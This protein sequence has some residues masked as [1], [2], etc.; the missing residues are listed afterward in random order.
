MVFPFFL[1]VFQFIQCF[2]GKKLRKPRRSSPKR[3]FF[4]VAQFLIS[5]DDSHG[6][7]LGNRGQVL[8]SY[9]RFGFICP[10]TGFLCRTTGAA[11]PI[12]RETSDEKRCDYVRLKTCALQPRTMVVCVAITFLFEIKLS[13]V[14]ICVFF[15]CRVW[16]A[17]PNDCVKMVSCVHPFSGTAWAKRECVGES[18]TNAV[19][20]LRQDSAKNRCYT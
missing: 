1:C 19:E 2:L 11:F 14:N 17:W 16:L 9:V 20:V 18:V 3:S 4:G 15:G 5:Y 8:M 7:R 10:A 12:T 6:G 13:G